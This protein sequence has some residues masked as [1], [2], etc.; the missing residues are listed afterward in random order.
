MRAGAIKLSRRVMVAAIV[1]AA[2]VC[3]AAPTIESHSV[4]RTRSRSHM[5]LACPRRAGSGAGASII[6]VIIAVAPVAPHRRS[7]SAGMAR[8]GPNIVFGTEVSKQAF[9]GPRR[10]ELEHSRRIGHCIFVF[11]FVFVDKIA[12]C[13]H[14]ASVVQIFD[15]A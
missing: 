12:R 2:I 6:F 7:A 15:H 8:L 5:C 9:H 3:A 14:M 1:S 11:G 4:G 13:C 10:H